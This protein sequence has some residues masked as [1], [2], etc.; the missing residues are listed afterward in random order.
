MLDHETPG[1]QTAS[2]RCGKEHARTK[3]RL[4]LRALLACGQSHGD[5][6]PTVRE[7]CQLRVSAHVAWVGNQADVVALDL[8]LAPPSLAT[9]IESADPPTMSPSILP[10]WM[11]TMVDVVE[12]PIVVSNSPAATFIHPT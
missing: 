4:V 3:R 11:R 7:N 6:E 10:S 12:Q 8:A 2:D 9:K 1:D 5:V